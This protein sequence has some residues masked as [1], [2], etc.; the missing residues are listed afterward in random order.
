MEAR[1]PGGAGARKKNGKKTK[2]KNVLKKTELG[3]VAGGAE[4][5]CRAAEEVADSQLA[6]LALPLQHIIRQGSHVK[7]STERMCQDRAVP[8]E[9]QGDQVAGKAS[10]VYGQQKAILLAATTRPH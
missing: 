10:Q 3:T 1:E 6:Q 5:N 4:A 9:S 7:C 8:S 2:T